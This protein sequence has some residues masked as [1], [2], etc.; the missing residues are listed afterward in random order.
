M[1]QPFSAGD[2]SWDTTGMVFWGDLILVTG[3]NLFF[4]WIPVLPTLAG[5]GI[6]IVAFWWFL[7]RPY[8][9][10]RMCWALI[11]LGSTTQPQQQES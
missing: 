3:I 10:R 4:F 11:N 1:T 2:I 9:Q 7:T 6:Q 8:G 5:F